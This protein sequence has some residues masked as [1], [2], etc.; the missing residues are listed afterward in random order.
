MAFDEFKPLYG[1]ALCVGWAQLHGHPIGI[2]LRQSEEEAFLGTEMVE[3]RATGLA[4]GRLQPGNG[5]P[6]IAELRETTA[7]ALENLASARTE[8]LATDSRHRGPPAILSIQAPGA[9]T[10][11]SKTD[12]PGPARPIN[13]GSPPPRGGEATSR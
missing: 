2:L 8:V 7:R 6:V 11:G 10:D 12:R 13:G 3:D 1:S 9:G 4:R 5:R